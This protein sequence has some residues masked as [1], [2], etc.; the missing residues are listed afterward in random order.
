MT[1]PAP[2]TSKKTI[3]ISRSVGG[4][5]L[6]LLV[7]VAIAS[8]A[9]GQLQPRPP[10]PFDMVGIIQGATLNGPAGC[11][12]CGGTLKINNIVITVPANTIVE[13]PATALAWGEV[14]SKNPTGNTLQTGLAT[15]DTQRLPVG[16]APATYEAHVQG[17]I[18]NGE[19]IAG[20]I[21]IS[22]Q[23][24]NLG[25]GFIDSIDYVKGEMHIMT[26]GGLSRVQINDPI[27]RFSK[28]Q[29]PDTRFTIDEDNPTV[30]S[31]T[32]YP[33]CLSRTNP[34]VANDPLCPQGNRPVDATKPGGFATTFHL[35]APGVGGNRSFKADAA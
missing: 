35:N 2:S 33:M 11:V 3:T 23:S 28:A 21:F 26:A 10:G 24:V 17:N 20:L 16:G 13:M 5:L 25:A 30:R 32:G 31:I 18:V 29:S 9:R 12:L 34:A 6:I 15:S 8:T 14:F 1:I 27:G 7:L 19:Y 4:R 22:Q